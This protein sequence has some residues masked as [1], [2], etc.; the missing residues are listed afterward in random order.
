[1]YK[2]LIVHNNNIPNLDQYKNTI[3]FSLTSS[4]IDEYISAE[5]INQIKDKE[6]SI[7]YIKDSLSS[8]YLE[9]N[10]LILAFHIR[11]S[12]E[13][14]SKRF[15]PIVILSDLDGYLLTKMNPIA[16]ILLTK[17]IFIGKNTEST[18]EYYDSLSLRNMSEEEYKDSFLNLIEIEPPKDYLS[19]H[20]ITNEWSIYRWSTFL[21]INNSQIIDDNKNK[22]SSMLYFK[23]IVA[24]YP[25]PFKRGIK[26]IP[27][28]PQAKGNILYIDDQWDRGWQVIFNTY[29]TKAKH[30]NFS[31]LEEVYKDKPKNE[32]IESLNNR[33]K[34]LNPD[35]IL[36]DLRLHDDDHIKDMNEEDFSGIQILKYIKEKIN[37]GIQVIILTASGNSL[38]IK[39]ANKYDIVGYVK[40]EHP[41]DKTVNAK[42]LNEIANRYLGL[43]VNFKSKK[44]ALDAIRSRKSHQRSG[45]RDYLN[46]IVLKN[47]PV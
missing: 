3:K 5:I 21:N 35:L 39:E 16:N 44:K 33:I 15:I 42:Q 27:T 37:P 31:T 32:L 12:S 34:D 40:K 30:I 22:I 8:N 36:L 29:F 41:G 10:G 4:S 18:I 11:L 43:N 45:A 9:L 28:P 24:K 20:S 14:G 38:I 6:C 1:M 26:F 17:N 2:N 47:I 23:Y 7:I 13:L 46:M 25:I 19:H